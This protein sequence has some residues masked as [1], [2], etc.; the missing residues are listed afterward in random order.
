MELSFAWSVARGAL[1]YGAFLLLVIAD[2]VAYNAWNNRCLTEIRLQASVGSRGS[3]L[4][5]LMCRQSKLARLS[6]PSRDLMPYSRAEFH[7]CSRSSL[8]DN[9]TIDTRR[10]TS[11]SL[12]SSLSAGNH[13]PTEGHQQGL[14][15]LAHDHDINGKRSSDCFSLEG[16]VSAL[17]DSYAD[18]LKRRSVSD[19]PNS[20]VSRIQSP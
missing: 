13:G 15:V 9:F 18:D 11:F 20:W 17:S 2:L 8:D 12:S 7:G 14:T 10:D 3:L 4:D 1:A 16:I 19:Q 6:T 5:A